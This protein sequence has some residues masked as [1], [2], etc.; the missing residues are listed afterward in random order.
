MFEKVSRFLKYDSNFFFD[1]RHIYIWTPRSITLPRSRCACG[2]MSTGVQVSTSYE[3][4][5]ELPRAI[6]TTDGKPV[7]GTKSNTTKALEKRYANATPPIITTSLK[8]GWVPETVVMEGMFLINITPWCAHKNIGEYADFLIRQHILRHFR[9]MSKQVHLLFD[10]PDC[11]E[12]SPKYFERQYRDQANEVPD[13][14]S[15]M[16]FSPDM[17]IPAKW[18][19]NVL[20]CRKCK[21][22][23]VCFLSHYFMERMKGKLGPQQRFVTAGGFEGNQ[24]GK[25]MFV[26]YNT[27]PQCDNALS[28]NAEESD[29]RIWLHVINSA[30]TKKLVLSPDTDIYHIGLP[31]ITTTE[32]DVVVQLSSFSSLEHRLLDMQ[33]LIKALRNDP[34]L[35]VIDPAF[36]SSVIQMIYYISTGCDFISF[37]N[38]FGKATFLATLFEYSG[39]ICSDTIQAPGILAD[40]DTNSNGFMSFLRLVGC[41]YFRKH[42]AVF[43]PSFPTPTTLFNSLFIDGQEPPAHHSA[44]LDLI[45]EKI[46]SRIKYEDEMVPSYEALLRHWQ[47]SCWVASVW[48][49]S[50]SNHITYPP[51]HNRG[52]KQPDPN[53]L[54]IDWDS[55]NNVS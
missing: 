38:G 28:C 12:M 52:W 36:S 30:G 17:S 16:Y 6:A 54:S 9:G 27:Q 32:F 47:R 46:W 31:I 4:C 44:W 51:L 2:V 7:K 26:T 42:K 37:F 18:R 20:N 3:Q 10:D 49:Q 25:A 5:L 43:L 11:Q 8:S 53:T 23:L 55:E 21:R 29:T 19:N 1:H 22:K 13:D 14:H 50:T 35:A 24:R 33:A 40:S 48:S 41:A 45:R 34:D 15:C 39:F